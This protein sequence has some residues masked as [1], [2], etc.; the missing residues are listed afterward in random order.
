[1]NSLRGLR[2]FISHINFEVNLGSNINFLKKLSALGFQIQFLSKD[3]KN[4]KKI[5]LKFIDLNIH[6]CSASS[7]PSFILENLKTLRMKSNKQ[8]FS[9]GKAFPSRFHLKNNSN[10]HLPLKNTNLLWEDL[11]HFLFYEHDPE[12]DEEESANFSIK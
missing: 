9:N 10:S 1:M 8:I 7:P 11:D 6:D 5:R 12:D 2:Q 4:I 3:S